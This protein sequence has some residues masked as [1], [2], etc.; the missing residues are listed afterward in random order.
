MRFPAAAP[1]S[2]QAGHQPCGGVSKTLP[3]GGST[4]TACQGVVADKQCTCPASRLM[5]E[6]YPLTPPSH[7]GENEIHASLMR[8]ASVGATP[9]PATKFRMLNV[10]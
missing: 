2:M 4:Q 9:T 7:C 6:R 5:R 1:I 10:E 8:S 3:A